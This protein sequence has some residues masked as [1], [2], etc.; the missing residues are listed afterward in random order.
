M[1]T[2]RGI[3]TEP[4]CGAALG[5]WPG[6]SGWT[7]GKVQ[8]QEHRSSLMGADPSPAAPELLIHSL[9]AEQL[10]CLCPCSVPGLC[11]GTGGLWLCRHES[12]LP[13]AALVPAGSP[14]PRVGK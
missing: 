6:S 13:Q 10:C 2:C 1:K 8:P 5:C 3:R 14:S 7:D 4:L 11:R 12:A 9:P